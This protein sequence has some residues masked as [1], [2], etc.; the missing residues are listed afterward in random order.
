MLNQH[1]V[2]VAG[3]RVYF[4]YI[5]NLVVPC[6]RGLLNIIIQTDLDSVLGINAHLC[7]LGI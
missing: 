4:H 2:A 3:Q 7:F 1:F 6:G 5:Y